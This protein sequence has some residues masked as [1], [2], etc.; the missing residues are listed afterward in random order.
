MNRKLMLLVVVFLAFSA[1]VLAA[2][3]KR[4]RPSE[5]GN[6]V[7]NNFS[8][9][10]STAPVVFNHW[11]HRSIYTC[12]LCHVDIGFAMTAGETGVKCDDNKAGMYCGACHNGKEAFGNET[13]D[14]SG[15]VTKNCFYCHSFG[16][17][18]RFKKDFYE[19]TKSFPKSKSGNRVDWLQAEEKGLVKLKDYLEGVSIKRKSINTPKDVDIRSK[20]IGM[21]DIIYSHQ[22][23]VIWNGCEVCHPAIF[24]VKRGA[25]KM[26]MM[27]IFN[28]KYCGVCHDKVAFP[29]SDCQLCHTKEV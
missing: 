5:Y 6:V 20:E 4:V 10:N 12:R 13:K 22:K 11:L 15:N 3:K 23:H 8:E 26:T 25:S 18:V 19:V 21:P 2:P 7:M 14:E 9:K 28:G 24:M 29:N 17:E 1:T 16:K 27:E